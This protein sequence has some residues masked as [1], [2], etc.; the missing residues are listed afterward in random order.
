MTGLHWGWTGVGE[1]GGVF[2]VFLSLEFILQIQVLL[3]RKASL[4][5]QKKTLVTLTAH[6]LSPQQM[7]HPTPICLPAYLFS[8]GLSLSSL[9][10][11]FR[12]KQCLFWSHTCISGA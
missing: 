4:R 8:V 5:P 12:Q 2:A 11:P 1:A 3:I 9:Q 10:V 6:F 7:H